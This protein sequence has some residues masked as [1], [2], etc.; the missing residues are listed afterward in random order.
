ML[1]QLFIRVVLTIEDEPFLQ[2]LQLVHEEHQKDTNQQSDKRGVEC[3]T[4]TL[5]DA[6]NISMDPLFP[7]QL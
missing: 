7:V 2:Q 6:S 4:K 1:D 3:N 5:C